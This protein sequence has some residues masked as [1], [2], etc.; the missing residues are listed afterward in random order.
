MIITNKHNIP[1][2]MAV[3]L[4]NDE[5]DYIDDPNYISA[6]SLMKP[7]RSLIL[8]KRI[9]WTNKERDLSELVASRFGS[10][11]HDSVEKAWVTRGQELLVKLGFPNDAAEKVIVNPSDQQ[12]KTIKDIIPIY[13]EKR[14]IKP[15]QGFNIGGKFDL[16]MNGH[17]YD[18]KSTS[19]F[20]YT[21]SG[22]DQHY[23]TQGSIYRWLNPKLITED[24]INIQFV[25]T[26]WQSFKARADPEYPQT[27]V[28]GREL[29]LMSLQETERYIRERLA[30]YA[31]Y[32]DAAEKDLPD[33]TREELWQSEPQYKY[34]NN[35]AKT[36]GRATRNFDSDK[37]AADE[38]MIG[39]P[40]I[41]KVIPGEPKRCGY[42]D[43]YETCS[44]RIRLNV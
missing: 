3:W 24:V 36:D 9:D 39:K 31:K 27:R 21:K 25:F 18:F 29:K 23:I 2:P 26:D 32:R 37:K 22:N 13:M 12:L 6:T 30:L 14:S 1:L 41:M 28:V 33:C 42:C 20:N 7:M 34:Y 15:F 43:A 8:S 16:V 11:I 38:F 40:G 10:A 35:P 17:L 5:Y 19:T 4:L 44:Q